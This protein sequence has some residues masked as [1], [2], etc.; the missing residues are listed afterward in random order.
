MSLGLRHVALMC[1]VVQARVLVLAHDPAIPL[2]V[3]VIKICSLLT[4]AVDFY[5]CSKVSN[6]V[7]LLLAD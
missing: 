7:A 5:Q 4:A 6:F 1:L 3:E 2:G